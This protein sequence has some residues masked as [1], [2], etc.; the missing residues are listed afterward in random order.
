MWHLDLK[1]CALP[2]S[3]LLLVLGLL[4]YSV[5]ILN[6]WLHEAF[7]DKFL[8]ALL[9][10]KTIC[11]K[12]LIKD[13]QIGLVHHKELQHL[14]F[15]LIYCCKNLL[16]LINCIHVIPFAHH[17]KQLTHELFKCC[18]SAHIVFLCLICQSLTKIWEGVSIDSTCIIV[19]L[20]FSLFQKRANIEILPQV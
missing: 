18:W 16:R 6:E 19:S 13:G 12:F 3:C 11:N 10:W 14:K 17:V 7:S 5:L 2:E 1:P 15:K 8:K 20:Y 4:F 9:S